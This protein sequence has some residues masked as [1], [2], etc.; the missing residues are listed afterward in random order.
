MLNAVETFVR[1]ANQLIGLF[2]ILRENRD[3]VIHADGD[4]KLQWLQQF[5]KDGLNAA[6]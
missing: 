6:A 5:Q 1:D 3:A 2:G 4:G